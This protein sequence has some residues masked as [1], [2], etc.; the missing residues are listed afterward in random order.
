VCSQPSRR[1][2]ISSTEPAELSDAGN[3]HGGSTK[4]SVLGIREFLAQTFASGQ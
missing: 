2:A 1:N 4:W 3:W